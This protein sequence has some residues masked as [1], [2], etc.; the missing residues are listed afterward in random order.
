MTITVVGVI[1]G[2]G[3]G[4]D[5]SIAH[6]FTVLENDVIVAVA[7]ANNNLNGVATNTPSSEFTTTFNSDGLGTNS[8]GILTQRVGATPPT[9]CGLLLDE[10]VS[11]GL[12]LI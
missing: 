3:S 9:I 1:T 7:N 2:S 5:P 6:G 4:N 11:W 12:G 8:Y 10:A